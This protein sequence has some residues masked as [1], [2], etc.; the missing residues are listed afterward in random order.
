M[1]QLIMQEIDQKSGSDNADV[2]R[3]DVE[4]VGG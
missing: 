4:G 3:S 2:R 1:C